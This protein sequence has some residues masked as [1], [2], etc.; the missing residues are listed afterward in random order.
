[1]PGRVQSPKSDQLFLE[2]TAAARH[3]PLIQLTLSVA[4]R[5]GISITQA[6]RNDTLD[7]GQGVLPVGIS[8]LGE[9]IGLPVLVL[10]AAGLA[11]KHVSPLAMG[12]GVADDGAPFALG[13]RH[14]DRAGERGGLGPLVVDG[15]R[16]RE[17][18][19]HGA[20]ER[21][22]DLDAVGDHLAL[23]DGH[24]GVGFVGVHDRGHGDVP[25]E[26]IFVGEGDDELGAGAFSDLV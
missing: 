19:L 22:P 7:P 4:T 16:D 6:S 26:E 10:A 12:Q 3:N 14:R 15:C 11:A 17:E 5:E 23:G 20:G 18:A 13:D 25:A 24:G 21:R 2:N 8:L 1:M 9:R